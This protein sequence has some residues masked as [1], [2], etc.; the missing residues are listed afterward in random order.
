[1]DFDGFTTWLLTIVDKWVYRFKSRS[2]GIPMKYKVCLVA[3]GNEQQH[4]MD[5][6][7]TFAL[8]AKWSIIHS[9]VSL[10]IEHGWEILHM[11]VNFF[12]LNKQIREDVYVKN[13]MDSSFLVFNVRYVN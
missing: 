5:F 1:M 11:D 4:G 12:F 3:C 6:Q 7:E 8:L 2:G 9:L 10:A 13:L